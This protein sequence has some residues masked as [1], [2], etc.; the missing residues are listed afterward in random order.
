MDLEPATGA[1]MS[2]LEGESLIEEATLRY[3]REVYE[4]PPAII[5]G[6]VIVAEFVDS[7]GTPDLHAFA[8]TGMPYW[9]INGMLEAAPHEIAYSD[10]DDDDD[11]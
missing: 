11:E 3:L 4:E 2:K 7:Q 8:M 1:D 9:K 5:T 10:E 6:W